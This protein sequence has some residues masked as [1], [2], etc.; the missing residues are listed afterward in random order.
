MPTDVIS[1]TDG[2]IYLEPDLFASG[3]RPAVNAGLSVTRVGSSAQRRGMKSVAG[4]MKLDMAQYREL[5]TFAQFGTADLDPATRRQLERGRR[6]TELLKQDET[7]PVSFENQ[8]ALFH[9]ANSGAFDDV[10][11][12]SVRQFESGW[13]DYAAAN[14]PDVLKEIAESGDLSDDTKEKLGEAAKG[15]KQTATMTVAGG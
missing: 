8:V 5:A 10:P 11:I 2:Q 13:Y 6:F 12:E 3:I 15:Y 1:I 7:Q 4:S 9:I 14:I